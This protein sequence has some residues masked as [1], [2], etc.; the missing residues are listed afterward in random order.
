MKEEVTWCV[1]DD[2]RNEDLRNW[3]EFWTHSKALL[4]LI[5]SIL[6]LIL[7]LTFSPP[8]RDETAF[9]QNEKIFVNR[10]WTGLT[11][12]KPNSLRFWICFWSLHLFCGRCYPHPMFCKNYFCLRTSYPRLLRV[13]HFTLPLLK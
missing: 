6:I 4:N 13:S 3:R 2:L 11:E 7:S 9:T 8:W 5:S 12:Q 1:V 10:N